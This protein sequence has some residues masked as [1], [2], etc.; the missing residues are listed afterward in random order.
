MS[1]TSL[2][3]LLSELD[4]DQLAEMIVELY[5]ARKEAREY[6]EYFV[7]PDENAML[8]KYKSVI[9]KEFF[10]A[11]S[12][13][14]ART[15]VCKK[16]VKE[17]TTLHPSPRNVAE[18]KLHLLECLIGYAVSMRSWIKQSVENLMMSAFD[19]TLHY[20]YANDLMN[21][22][23]PRIENMLLTSKKLKSGLR[24]GLEEVYDNFWNSVV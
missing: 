17:F 15:S 10:P 3:K 4:R 14:R 19:D 16:A 9:Q 2:K 18:L 23:V 5:E 1:K 24:D 21:D 8:E 6:L 11:K 22:M 13:P 12:R 7:S 20:L